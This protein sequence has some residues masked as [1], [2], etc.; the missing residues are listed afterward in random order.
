M[1]TTIFK[2]KNLFNDQF[3]VSVRVKV[4]DGVNKFVTFKYW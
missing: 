1:A 3:R 4:M 2:H